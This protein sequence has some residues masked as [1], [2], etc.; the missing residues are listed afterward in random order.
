M[1]LDDYQVTVHTERAVGQGIYQ[2]SQDKNCPLGTRLRLNDGRTFQYCL[3]G[4]GTLA[5][6]KTVQGPANLTTEI[7]LD[8]G[9]ND[10]GNIP[11]KGDT[12]VTLTVGSTITA[13]LYADGYF[14][15]TDDTAEG[16]MYKIKS[17]PAVTSGAD[18]VFTLYDSIRV[19]CA[20]A[21]TYGLAKNPY[22]GVVIQLASGTTQTSRTVGAPLIP[23]TAAYFFWAQTWGDGIGWLNG[24]EG[25]GIALMNSTTAG[26]LITADGTLPQLA[27][28]SANAGATADYKPV[29]WTISP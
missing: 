11:A 26:Q 3:N 19:A 21:T 17:H 6:A 20:A 15:T 13:D 7:D 14:Y 4:A 9:S 22:S 12:Q 10:A 1:A 23:V 25:V 16:Q 8:E 5:L 24:T 29:F 18:G 2:E 28:L 27:V